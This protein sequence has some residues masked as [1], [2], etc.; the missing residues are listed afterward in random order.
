MKTL[1]TRLDEV[2]AWVRDQAPAGTA[3]KIDAATAR[4]AGSGIDER[5]LQPGQQ[6]PDF[7]LPDATG[8]LVRSAA[9]RATGPLVLVFYRGAWCPYCNL[10]LQAWQPHLAALRDLG[11]T[12]LAI[13]PQTPD[14]ALSQREKLSLAH[15]VLSDAGNAVARRFGLVFELDESLRP[16]YAGFGIDLAA[17]NGD[18]SFELPVPATY[19]IDR[20]GRVAGVWF[21]V[22]YR[23]RPEPEDVMAC[24]ARIART[25]ASQ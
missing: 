3:D 10:A 7:D 1:Q 5:A 4:L 21:D 25:G 17:H 9:L 23:R 12:L 2:S 15:P 13:S 14:V 19:V 24:V 22:D 16:V 18:R 8:V 11:A 20:D 6:A